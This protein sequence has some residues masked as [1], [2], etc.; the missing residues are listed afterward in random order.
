MNLPAPSFDVTS[1]SDSGGARAPGMAISN[2]WKFL[3]KKFQRLE[4]GGSALVVAL[5]V[6]L[7]LSL[8]VTTLA[9]DMRIES[10][11]ASYQRKRIKAQYLSRA[12]LEWAKVALKKKVQESADGELVIE[13][14]D[15]PQMIMASLNLS[16]GVGVS[17]L[18]KELGEGKFVLDILP[19][20]ARR[21][22]NTLT[23]E[24]W[25][26]ILDQSGVDQD[27]WDDLMDAFYDWVDE[28]DNHR[29]HGAEKDDNFYTDR[30]YEVKNAPLDTVD[31]LLMIKGFNERILYGG[32]GET[33][34]DP[35]LLGIAGWLTTWGDG[36]VNINTA[37]REVLLTLPGID[38]WV[39]DA[40]MEQRL[41]PDGQAGTKDDGFDTVEDAI[42]KTGMD[43]ELRERVRTKDYQFLRLVSI[44]EV[45]GVRCGIWCVM[46]V[47]GGSVLPVY[48]REEN[49]P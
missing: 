19:E 31:E 8:L 49:M 29:L 5:W 34:D 35:P 24:D 20:E 27:H 2:R 13:E 16:R 12:G 25:Y 36:K 40:I 21:N 37:S 18:E 47:G 32:P 41:G 43:P 7:V 23:Q 6:L 10:S 22:V 14:G 33:K 11:I 30:D 45:H 44:G 28:D 15:D 9:F 42:G 26:E 39:V 48:W 1:S 17:G 46:Q 3:P 38:D 4:K